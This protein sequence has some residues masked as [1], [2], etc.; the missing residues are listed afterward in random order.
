MPATCSIRESAK[1]WLMHMTASLRDNV[2]EE[3]LVDEVLSTLGPLAHGLVNEDKPPQNRWQLRCH[4][5][6]RCRQPAKLAARGQLEELKRLLDEDPAILS[7][8]R[9]GRFSWLKLPRGD[10]PP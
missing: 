8:P 5:E 10:A 6:K 9:Q 2:G 3:R 7:D 4:R 1:R